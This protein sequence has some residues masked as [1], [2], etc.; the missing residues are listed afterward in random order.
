VSTW[1][2]RTLEDE[3]QKFLTTNKDKVVK[4]SIRRCTA[5]GLPHAAALMAKVQ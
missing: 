4:E 1:K 3:K 2:R 5:D